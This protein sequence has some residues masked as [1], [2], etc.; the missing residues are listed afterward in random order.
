MHFFNLRQIIVCLPRI[1]VFA[2]N[3][4]SQELFEINSVNK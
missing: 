3:V 1:V 4:H 2:Q